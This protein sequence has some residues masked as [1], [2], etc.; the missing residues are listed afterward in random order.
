M[1]YARMCSTLTHTDAEGRA[2]MVDVGHKTPTRR[3]A[4]ASAR[5]LL[6]AAAFRAVAANAVAKGD[7]LATAELAG[8]MAAKR[9]PDLSPLC[10]P[11]L[12]SHARVVLTLEEECAAV[13]ITAEV[14]TTGPTGVEME[15][16]TAATTAALTVYDMCKAVSKRI[17][18][19][20]VQLERKSGGKGGQ[21]VRKE[22]EPALKGS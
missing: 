8:V 14:A 16:L 2:R 21:W 4:V 17:R 3:V 22:A 18:I 13:A 19:T 5:V 7:V 10:H 20:D 15:A 9:V 11:L 1:G 12:I 6:G